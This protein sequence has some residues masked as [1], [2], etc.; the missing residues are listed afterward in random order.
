MENYVAQFFSEDV[1]LLHLP[2]QP[3]IAAQ[4]LGNGGKIEPYNYTIIIICPI[5]P[6]FPRKLK[7]M[8][9]A[10]H[11]KIHSSISYKNGFLNIIINFNKKWSF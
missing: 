5:L 9:F 4:L 3:T 8:N 2:C 1:I 11:Y 10:K 6:T 7:T